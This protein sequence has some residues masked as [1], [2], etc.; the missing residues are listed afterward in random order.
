MLTWS[1]I[2]LPSQRCVYG[3]IE[4]WFTDVWLQRELIRKRSTFTVPAVENILQ[5][6]G[7]QKKKKH[8]Q[9]SCE[10]QRMSQGTPAVHWVVEVLGTDSPPDG[11]DLE[12]TEQPG[13]DRRSSMFWPWHAVKIV[14]TNPSAEPAG[15]DLTSLN[16]WRWT[17]SSRA[18]RL[19][20][21]DVTGSSMIS[22]MT[23]GDRLLYC[24]WTAG[25]ACSTQRHHWSDFS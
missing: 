20:L 10:E 18:R 11:T 6:P 19:R 4:L 13:G 7:F 22:S 8:H 14:F 9:H 25:G 17:G 23:N 3:F 2:A 15:H 5:N 24:K 1:R 21:C 16:L 12:T